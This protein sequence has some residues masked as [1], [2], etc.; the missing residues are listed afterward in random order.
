VELLVVIAI[1]GILVALLLPAIQAAREAARRSQ[2]VNNLKQ[3]GVAMHNYHDSNKAFPPGWIYNGT[4][5]Q[6]EWGWAV[7]LLPYLEQDALYANLD[8][9]RL[10]LHALAVDPPPSTE[11]QTLLQ[12]SIPGF[13]C[14]SDVSKKLADNLNFG[15][16]ANWRL[17]K[18]NYIACAAW[19]TKTDGGGTVRYPTRAYDSGGMF[20][21]NS[22]LKMSD[23]LDGTSTT[24]MC[25][26]RDYPHHA[27]TWAGVG[28]NDSYGNEGTPRCTFRGTFIINFDFIAAGAPQNQAKGWASLH[29][30]GVN[31]LS[32]DA[33][34]NFLSQSANTAVLQSMCIRDDGNAIDLPW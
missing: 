26:E 15:T 28:N 20:Y 11:V 22:Y 5:G 19:S 30:G 7:N 14:P 9:C 13:L 23:C 10:R 21:G 8:P 4:T 29:P 24:I 18:S 33:S 17:A 27:A 3:I 25:S 6:K 12:T 2:C 1:I 31:L 34:V 16:L 32:C